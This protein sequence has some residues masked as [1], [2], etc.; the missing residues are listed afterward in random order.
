MLCWLRFDK[1]CKVVC[2]ESGN[3]CNADVL[4]WSLRSKKL[5]EVEIKRSK[6]DFLN[7]FRNKPK[8]HKMLDKVTDSRYPHFFYY[9]V[10]SDLVDFVC[11][12]LDEKGLK[13]YG[14]LTVPDSEKAFRSYMKVVRKPEKL[15]D[16]K[17][18]DHYIDQLV[19]RMSSELC[20]LHLG[21][22]SMNDGFQRISYLIRENLEP[23]V[24]KEDEVQPQEPKYELVLE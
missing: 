8:K 7:D 2:T 19:S 18:R 22:A 10:T 11:E 16:L 14:I 1:Q 17:P 6:N 9:A 15:H 20:N 12:T 21:I 5:F 13:K 24:D 3:P 23:D 4:G